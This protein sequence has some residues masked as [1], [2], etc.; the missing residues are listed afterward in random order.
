MVLHKDGFDAC[1]LLVGH[2]CM[3]KHS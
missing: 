1:L 2:G 3:V